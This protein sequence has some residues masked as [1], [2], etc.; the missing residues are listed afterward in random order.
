MACNNVAV[1]IPFDLVEGESP[2]IIG[3]HLE[4]LSDIL[5]RTQSSK[6]SFKRPV[7]V[8]EKKTPDIHGK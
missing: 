6:I 4:R 3:L 1:T 2:L 5:N 8:V 7:Y